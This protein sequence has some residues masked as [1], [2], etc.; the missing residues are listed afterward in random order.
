M[1]ITAIA[2]R[3]GVSKGSVSVWVRDIALTEAQ[4]TALRAHYTHYEN[5]HRGSRAVAAKYRALRQTYQAEG[6]HK[7]REGDPLHLA[8]C[9]LYWAEG[10]QNAQFY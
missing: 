5:Q 8:G 4:Q 7:A 6:R 1:A 2:R 10:R 9:M 3:L